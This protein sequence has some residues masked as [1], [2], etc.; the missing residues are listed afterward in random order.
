MT[1]EGGRKKSGGDKNSI[2]PGSGVMLRRGEGVG[3][4][5]GR[6]KKDFL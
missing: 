2:K 5:R 6:G 1:V 3:W 4:S